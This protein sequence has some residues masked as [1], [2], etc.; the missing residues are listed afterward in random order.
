MFFHANRF[1]QNIGSWNVSNVTNMTN[2]FKNVTLSTTNYDALLTGWNSLPL[3]SNVKFSGGKSKYCTGDTART[4]MINT[5]GWT[6]TDGGQLCDPSVAFVTTWQTTTNNETITIPTIGSGYNY[7]I[8]WGDGSGWQIGKTGDATKSYAVAGSYTVT[9]QGDFPRIYF[10]NAGDRLKIKSIEQWGD[11]VWSSMN[12]AFTGC[13]NLIS[14]ATDTPDLSL[15][16]DMHGMFAYARAFNGDA[17]MGNWDVSN[18]TNMNGMFAG[19]SVFNRAIGNWNVGNVTTMENMFF[20]ATVF[21]QDIGAWNVGNVITMKNMFTT[22]MAFNQDISNWNVSNVITMNSMF[23]HANQFDQNIGG[24]NVSN[25]TNMAS[26][27]KSVTLSTANYDAL[28][29][30]WN[31][32]SLKNNVK[33]S[34][35]N[36]KYCDGEAA[37]SNMTNTF[38]W[39]ITDGGKECFGPL[40]ERLEVNSNDPLFGITLYP[41]P[42]AD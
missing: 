23:T 26:M 4:Y 31:S 18:V 14:N 8:N 40:A 13:E 39:T 16:T 34:G 33:F 17:N 28:L 6:I 36:S 10:N 1:N 20:G 25:V 38:G 19:A 41:N 11:V 37:R 35:G 27:F 9:I 29:N 15:V 5:R 24:W 32:Q 21:N 42:M 3:K 12:N 7:D 30:G 2:M 22:A